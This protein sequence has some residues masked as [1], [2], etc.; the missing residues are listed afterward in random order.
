MLYGGALFPEDCNTAVFF[1][2][3]RGVVQLAVARVSKT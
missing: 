2:Y 1:E 3:I